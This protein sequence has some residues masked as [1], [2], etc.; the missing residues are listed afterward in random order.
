M[1]SVLDRP[2]TAVVT[3][4][5]A[6]PDRALGTVIY[7]ADTYAAACGFLLGIKDLRTKIGDTFNPHIKRAHDAHKALLKE[8]SDAEAPLI[9]AERILKTTIADYDREQEQI[10]LAEQRRLDEEARRIAEERQLEEAVALEAAGATT[11]AVAVLET[12][13]QPV[14][15]A[16]VQKAVPKVAGVSLK[17]V[18][19]FRI[20]DES[21]VPDQYKVIDES[22]IRG[23][24]RSLG[25]AANIPGVQVYEDTQVAAGRR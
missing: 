20:V 18:Y 10:R 22:K 12:P 7:D 24:V 17:K 6:W 16:P 3:E 1:D 13:V 21:K 19:A 8:K 25:L 4:A 2:D 15:L 11:E 9:E 14:P 5:K 23:V